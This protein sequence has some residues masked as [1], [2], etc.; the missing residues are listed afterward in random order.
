LL[1][2]VWVGLDDYQDIKL[3]GAKAAL[4]IWTEFMKLAH[5]HRAYRDVTEFPVPDGVVSAQIDADTGQL[6]TSACP[7]VV[8]DYYLLGTQ[9]V[10]FC[11]LHQG[12]STEIA[13]W[14]SSPLPST[15]TPVPTVMPTQAMSQPPQG[16]PPNPNNNPQEKPKKKSFFDKLKSIFH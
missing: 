2:I 1:C 10:Q 7:R 16:T 11:M 13:G 8:T 9:P 14:E 5:K 15:Q 6:A 3:D 4:P 12:G